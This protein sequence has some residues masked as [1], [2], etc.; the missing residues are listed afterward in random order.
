MI[1]QGIAKRYATAL[2]NSALKANVGGDVQQD[3]VGFREVFDANKDFRNFLLS[4]RVLT[5]DKKDL[6]KETFDGR[7]TKLFVS[8]LLLLIDKKRVDFVG[9]IV[10]GYTYLYERHK[11]VVEVRAITAVPL[12]EKMQKKV[13]DHLK[14]RIGKDVRLRTEVDPAIIGGMVLIMDDKILDGSVRYQME[15]LKRELDEIRI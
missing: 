15:K 1:P 12:E 7:A 13:L 9:D 6:I 5:K 4:P 2:L 10:D 3:A 11:G 8:F 14:N